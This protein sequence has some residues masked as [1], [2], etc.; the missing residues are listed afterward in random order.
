M[1]YLL[2]HP[3]D[4]SALQNYVREPIAKLRAHVPIVAI[5]DDGF[6]YADVLRN[7]GF[8]ITV[9]NDISDVNAVESYPIIICD[10]K[11]VGASFKSRFEGAH[12]IS[13]IRKHYPLKYLIV[14]TGQMFDASYNPYFALCDTSMKKDAGSDEWVEALDRAISVYVDPMSQWKKARQLVISHD[15]PPARLMELEDEYVRSVLDRKKPFQNQ[16]RLLDLPSDLKAV[17]LG[18]ASNVVFKLIAG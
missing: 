2:G 16:K 7:H 11:G 9:L 12:V 13:E 4:V 18:V 15:I 5:D 1:Y 6:A 8:R 3:K 10:I 17:L 14:Y